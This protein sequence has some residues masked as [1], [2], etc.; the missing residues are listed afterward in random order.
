MTASLAVWLL[1]AGELA[2][3]TPLTS[4]PRR[5]IVCH[6]EATRHREMV[7]ALRAI[8]DAWGH[9]AGLD[10]GGEFYTHTRMIPA[11][12]LSGPTMKPFTSC[13]KMSGMRFWLQSRMKRIRYPRQSA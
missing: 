3:A 8:H 10:F 12:S 1:L 11:F 4:L 13:R 2:A 5:S 9:G 6:A 7:L